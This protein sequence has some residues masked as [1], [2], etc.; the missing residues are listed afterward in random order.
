MNVRH[1][2]SARDRVFV[3][4]SRRRVSTWLDQ[5]H[6]VDVPTAYIKLPFPQDSTPASLPL[7]LTLTTGRAPPHGAT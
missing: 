3:F 4:L 1:C 6:L 2:E 5:Q 7:F